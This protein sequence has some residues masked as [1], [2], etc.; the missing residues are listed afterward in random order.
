MAKNTIIEN[1]LLA[2]DIGGFTLVPVGTIVPYPGEQAPLGWM[3]CDGRSITKEEYPELYAV[4]GSK[5]PDLRGEFIRGLDRGR[6]IDSNRVLGTAQGD[7]IRNLA[8]QF[9][10]LGTNIP[11]NL[12]DTRPIITYADGIFQFITTL[13]QSPGVDMLGASPYGDRS[14]FTMKFD[15]S[16]I[17]P[18]ANEN[19]P[20]NVAMNY[21][22]KY[23]HIA[24][25]A[26]VID[27]EV[28]LNK[29][30][31]DNTNLIQANMGNGGMKF[32]QTPGEK[33]S[34][35]IYYD[36]DT[37]PH[38]PYLC[39]KDNTDITP[40]SNFLIANNNK[41]TNYINQLTYYNS[42]TVT[43]GAHEITF[44][45]FGLYVS[46]GVSTRGGSINRVFNNTILPE[47]LRPSNRNMYLNFPS[48]SGTPILSI[49][50]EQ[51]TL[52]MQSADNGATMH[53][54]QSDTSYFTA[55]SYI[56]NNLSNM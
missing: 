28:E 29:K 6:G 8:G 31:E 2:V 10:I 17:A 56:A 45:R 50:G 14:V 26:G 20:R 52:R 23:R 19:R 7:A 15:A 33:T 32:I 38:K 3:F 22:I 46:V 5:V 13:T 51:D 16:R 54:L 1:K 48:V 55:S 25:H 53:T 34:G 39:L 49:I 37:T 36:Q 24:S 11:S 40:T 9:D 18:T 42:H 30:I 12:P 21:I 43:I 41:I 47:W 27:S 4:V 44:K 35:E